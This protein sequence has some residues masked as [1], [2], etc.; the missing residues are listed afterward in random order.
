MYLVPFLLQ[1]GSLLSTLE[2]LVLVLALIGIVFVIGRFFLHIIYQL[3]VNSLLGLLSL[4]LINSFFGVAIVITLPV[5]LFVAILGLP[6]VFI[7]VLL[8]LV[9]GWAV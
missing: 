7:L 4:F 5:F 1:A 3:V 8:K 9:L 2:V 6:A